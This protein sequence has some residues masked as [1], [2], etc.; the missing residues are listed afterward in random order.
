MAKTKR[1]ANRG[2]TLVELLLAMAGVA[3]LLISIT[4]TT[5]QLT[6]MYHKGI[7][8]KSINQS[9]REVGDLIRRDGL[10]VGQGETTDRKS[11]V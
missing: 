2:F 11:V 9:G 5:I 10:V 7:T 4:V 8:I 3:V 6:N 1:V